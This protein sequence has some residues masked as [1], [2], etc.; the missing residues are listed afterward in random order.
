MYSHRSAAPLRKGKTKTQNDYEGGKPK[1]KAK[2]GTRVLAP[3]TVE[4]GLNLI[5]ESRIGMKP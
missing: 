5:L 1:T 3:R 2:P 4:N